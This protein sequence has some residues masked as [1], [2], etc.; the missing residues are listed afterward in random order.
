M[1]AKCNYSLNEY[2]IT[3]CND[4]FRLITYWASAYN[5]DLLGAYNST[6]RLT[7]YC[8]VV[9]NPSGAFC[10]VI[11]PDWHRFNKN[12][13]IIH[14]MLSEVGVKSPKAQVAMLKQYITEMF[15]EYGFRKVV[16]EF[17]SIS[18][19][20]GLIAQRTGLLLEATMRE[21]WETSNG[22]YDI[23]RYGILKDEWE[24]LNGRTTEDTTP[25]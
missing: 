23:L 24:A 21:E 17:P 12:V 20:S 13:L 8:R 6:T 14:S 5:G 10:A 9:T 19:L 2:S 25:T 16:L 15:S 18:R 1:Q 4:A 11:Y 7:K 3:N 22:Y